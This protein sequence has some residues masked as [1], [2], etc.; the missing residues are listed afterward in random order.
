M[1][2]QLAA[3]RALV[4]QLKGRGDNV[5]GQAAHVGTGFPLRRF[6]LDISDGKLP[7]ISSNHV[8]DVSKL[9]LGFVEEF[10]SELEKFASHLI[11][12]NQTLQHENKQ[13]SGL[14]KEY[15]TTLEDVMS[16]FRGVAVSPN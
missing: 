4:T 12:E 16:K 7:N 9:T 8:L 11:L 13:L 1:S 15:E 10:N 5:K 6:N 2:D 3:N 14:L